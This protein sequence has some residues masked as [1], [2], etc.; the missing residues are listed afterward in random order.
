V[1]GGAPAA[2]GQIIGVQAR[3]VGSVDDYRDECCGVARGALVIAGALA[4]HGHMTSACGHGSQRIRRGGL[5]LNVQDPAPG[6]PGEGLPVGLQ[7]VSEERVG[8]A[9]GQSGGTTATS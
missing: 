1:T 9:I 4:E 5:E 6:K 7:V 3:A 2:R 8:G